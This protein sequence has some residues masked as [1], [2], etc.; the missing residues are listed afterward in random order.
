MVRLLGAV[1]VA[2]GAAWLGF[3]AAAGI[4]ERVRALSHMAG[5]LAVLEQELELNG[6]PLSILMRH[7][8]GRSRGCAQELFAA[9]AK[10]MEGLEGESFSV[11]WGRL[12]EERKELGEEGRALMLSLGGV[13]GRCG[14]I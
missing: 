14:W 3:G 7:A 11:L 10:G 6:A 13:L 1:L 2:A 8:A 5:G 12:V 4:R 9:C